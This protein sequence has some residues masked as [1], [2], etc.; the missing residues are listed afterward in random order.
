MH[1][2]LYLSR[3]EPF[4]KPNREKSTV[5]AK[6]TP[7][8]SLPRKLWLFWDSGIENASAANQLCYLNIVKNAKEAGFE[9]F[10]VSNSNLKDHLPPE[11][12]SRI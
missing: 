9:V 1:R 6:F 11:Y 12:I 5:A 10:E 2:H 7:W 4:I 8:D 3:S